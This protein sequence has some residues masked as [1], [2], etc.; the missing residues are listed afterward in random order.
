MKNYLKNLWRALTGKTGFYLTNSKPNTWYKITE[1]G[2]GHDCWG[3]ILTNEDSCFIP[4]VQ[5]GDM[6][7]WDE[8]QKENAYSVG[9]TT[10]DG[11]KKIGTITTDSGSM[12]ETVNEL[13][14]AVNELEKVI[15]KL[16]N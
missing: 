15:G 10:P 16:E 5:Y 7:T 11:V 9:L 4:F 14:E 12:S 8:P 6:V 13:S 2:G 3:C 1:M